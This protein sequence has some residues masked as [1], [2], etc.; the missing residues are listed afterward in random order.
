MARTASAK[1]ARLVFALLIG[2]LISKIL[3][4]FSIT[5][6]NFC[7]SFASRVLVAA[8]TGYCS[9][10]GTYFTILLTVRIGMCLIFRQVL[11]QQ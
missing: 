4:S 8:D 10:V 9:S 7:V 2:F 5:G 1:R 11:H 3:V 6:Y